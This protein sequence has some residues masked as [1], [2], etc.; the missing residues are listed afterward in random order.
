MLCPADFEP[1]CDDLCYGG[2]CLR[3]G[4]AMYYHCACGALVSVD[5]SDECC[6]P[7]NYDEDDN[8]PFSMGP[9]HE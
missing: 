5:D 9:D 3:N 2:G 7:M 6:C 1:C 4:M 8:L